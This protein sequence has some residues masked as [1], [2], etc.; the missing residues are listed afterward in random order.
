[1]SWQEM[2]PPRRS[3]GARQPGTR[4]LHASFGLNSS[5]F[6]VSEIASGE[7]VVYRISL[8]FSES[9]CGSFIDPGC[10][11]SRSAGSPRQSLGAR[12]VSEVG[13]GAT[14]V[15]SVR[16][17]LRLLGDVVRK[18]PRERPLLLFFMCV[19]SLSPSPSALPVPQVWQKPS[20]KGLLCAVV[21]YVVL[22]CSI[23]YYITMMY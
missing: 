13:R 16:A 20:S 4:G 22:Y 3:L 11:A 2:L 17:L 8:P 6:A 19:R 7:V 15:S 21:Y 12:R 9:L 5:T 23:V 18:P 14:E 10:G 1:M